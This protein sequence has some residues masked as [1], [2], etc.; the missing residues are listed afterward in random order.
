MFLKRFLSLQNEKY[1]L[2]AFSISTKWKKY[3]FEAFSVFTKWQNMFSKH[4]AT[5]Q[6]EKTCFRNFFVITRRKTRFWSLFQRFPSLEKQKQQVFEALFMWTN[7]K[8]SFGSVFYLYK[9][10]KHV[11]KRFSCL[12]TLGKTRC[13]LTYEWKNISI[14]EI[15]HCHFDDTFTGIV[16]VENMK[17]PPL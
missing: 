13:N 4:F 8:I 14:I 15:T 5:L 7:Q 10:K 6:N 9:W 2:E 3:V 11:S 12:Q 1:V 17:N 16:G